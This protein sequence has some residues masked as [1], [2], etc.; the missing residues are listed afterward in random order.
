[1]NERKKEKERQRKR[2]LVKLGKKKEKIERNARKVARK[3]RARRAT[4]HI[5]TQA[6]ANND[7]TPFFIYPFVV[8]PFSKSRL[9]SI[10]IYIYI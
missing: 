3:P 10:H 9:S 2:I 6:I 7:V 4:I 5:L 8:F 1:M